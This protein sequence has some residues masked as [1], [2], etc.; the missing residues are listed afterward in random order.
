MCVADL[1]TA[2]RDSKNFTNGSVGMCSLGFPIHMN[3]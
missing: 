3:N 2:R 1:F